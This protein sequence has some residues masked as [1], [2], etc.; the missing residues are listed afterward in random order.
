MRALF[1][2]T[3]TIAVLSCLGAVACGGGGAEPATSAASS[4]GDAPAAHAG[5]ADG[6]AQAAAAE[7]TLDPVKVSPEVYKVLLDGPRARVLEATWQ[8]GQ[9]DNPHGH[10]LLVAYALTPVFGLGNEADETQV[11][12][13]IR[14]EQALIQEP[15]STHAFENRGKEAAKL[16]IVEFKPGRPS[17]PA[18]KGLKEA[19]V[20]SPKHYE[21]VAFDTRIHVLRARFQ[22]GEGGEYYGQPATILH[23]LTDIEGKLYDADEKPRPLSVKAGTTM[24]LEPEEL[25]FEN[26]GAAP[27]EMLLIEDKE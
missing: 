16:L 23:A 8:P 14:K 21:L 5:D 9:R 27:V 3:V 18:P 20:A 1:V 12:I 4:G 6:E 24:F 7:S 19:Q 17:A 26:T 10:P 13:R 11:S 22:P 2:M 15:V 25:R